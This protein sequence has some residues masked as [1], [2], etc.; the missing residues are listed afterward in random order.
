MFALEGDHSLMINEKR[1]LLSK[2][3]NMSERLKG[4]PKISTETFPI[5]EREPRP[6]L[7]EVK[8]LSYQYPEAETLTLDNISF[9]INKGEVLGVVGDSGSG[10]TTLLAALSGLI[11]HFYKE[12]EYQGKVNFDGQDVT[13]YSV[14]NLMRNIGLVFQDPETQSFGMHVDDAIAFGME[15]IGVPKNEM[16]KRIKDLKKLLKIEHLSRKSMQDLSG[17]ELQATTI[18]TVLA[19][20]PKMLLFDEIISALDLGGQQRIKKLIK[21]FKNQDRTMVIVDSDVNWLS[22]T[23]DRL[24]VLDQGKLAYDGCPE[25]VESFEKGFE[26]RE[27]TEGKKNVKLK[28]ISFSYNGQPA[29]E[30]VSLEI[31]SGSCTALVGHNGSGKTTLAK[32]ISGLLTPQQGKVEINGLNPSELPAKELIRKVGYVYQTP[33]EMFVTDS[34]EE[35]VEI[36]C[37][38]GHKPI[39]ENCGLTGLEQQSPYCL[40]AGQQQRLA[41]ASVVA[42]GPEIIILDEPTLGQTRKNRERLIN[43]IKEL[44]QQEKTVILISHDLDL[45]AKAAQ[46]IHVL[47]NGHIVRA[48]AT[49]EVLEDKDF[50]NDLGLPLPW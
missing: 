32:I 28:N 5:R 24:L 27:A 30:N 16:T 33:S 48:G 42:S 47:N 44:Q 31:T 20:E 23:V 22:D 2:A 36:N 29:L 19:M 13:D 7:V 14:F 46:Q 38:N 17:G 15:N 1:E 3:L 9:S 4:K 26:L 35:E 6:S 37:E 50:F 21:S 39:F 18:A 25:G 12:G 10:K 11:P 43:Q 8:N 41:I 40:S 34:V 49:K 45:V